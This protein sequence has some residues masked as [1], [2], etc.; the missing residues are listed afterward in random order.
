MA[1]AV[2]VLEVV[3]EEPTPPLS[4]PVPALPRPRVTPLLLPA[5][6]IPPLMFPMS[7]KS[8]FSHSG[9]AGNTSFHPPMTPSIAFLRK[10]M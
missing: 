10:I 2:L 8:S 7:P 4:M 9:H 5:L 6:P 3:M 1:W